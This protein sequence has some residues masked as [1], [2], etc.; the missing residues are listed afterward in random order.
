M[1][2]V[3]AGRGED[4]EP[5]RAPWHFWVLVVAAVVYLGWRLVQMIGWLVT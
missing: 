3:P 5:Y 4:A 2:T 1:L